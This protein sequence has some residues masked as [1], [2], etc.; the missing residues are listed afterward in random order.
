MTD[1]AAVMARVADASV[2][3]DLDFPDE[4]W[5]GCLAHLMNNVVKSVIANYCTSEILLVALNDFRSMKRIIEDSTRSER[6]IL[7]PNGRRLIQNRN[8][9]LK[10]INRS[11]RIF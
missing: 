9:V 6:N 3:K 10:L 2:S 7:L 1:S 8:P 4:T 5:M 11:R